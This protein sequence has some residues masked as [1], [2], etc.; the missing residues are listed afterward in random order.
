M[1]FR[2]SAQPFIEN[3]SGS[4]KELPSSNVFGVKDI[5]KI[6]TLHRGSKS[7]IDKVYSER[8]EKTYIK[9][10][11][12]YNKK[13]PSLYFLNEIRFSNLSHPNVISPI[14]YEI[15]VKGTRENPFRSSTIFMEYAP[16]G[17]FFELLMSKRIKFDDKLIRT[18]FQQ[19]IN[20]LEFL[21]SNGVA[22]MDIKMENLAIGENY[23][24]KIIDF[25]LSYKIGD[26]RILSQGT[27]HYRA[28]E[29]INK[30]CNCP[31]KADIYAA[32]IVL[33]LFKSGG[34]LPHI[35]GSTCQGFDMYEL[36]Q[37]DP[38]HFWQKHTE[39]QKKPESYWDK[40]FKEL[41]QMMTREDPSSRASIESIKRNAWFNEEIY[42]AEEI[43]EIMS[44]YCNKT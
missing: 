10:T 2:E 43:A 33:F 14:Y 5:C 13:K 15:D 32:G 42:T 39:I 8:N 23:E 17:D 20:G 11:F 3:S 27:R 34:V 26:E 9:K 18:F 19:L 30:H 12:L 1:N 40:S 16:N 7:I 24:L 36:L 29:I 21:H 31:E 6:Q 38:D 41:F 35:E 44:D 37:N 4:Q 25:G 28:P 22:H